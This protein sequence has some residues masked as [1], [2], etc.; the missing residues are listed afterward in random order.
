VSV[1]TEANGELW[2]THEGSQPFDGSLGSPCRGT[3]DFILPWLLWSAQYK[4]FF[5]ATLFHLM[6]VP[7]AQQPGQAVVQDPLSLLLADGR[8]GGGGGGAKSYNGEKVWSYLNQTIL[9]WIFF[10]LCE[11]FAD[12]MLR[13][14]KGLAFFT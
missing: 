6:C 13:I 11:D 5:L 10:S 3:R 2:S 7:I 9:S 1:E 12:Q 4:I 14:A 8:G